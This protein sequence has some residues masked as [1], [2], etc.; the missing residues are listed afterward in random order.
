MS[1]TKLL[2]GFCKKIAFIQ[3]GLT[4]STGYDFSNL[5]LSSFL[6][7]CNFSYYN[8]LIFLF[9]STLSSPKFIN[10]PTFVPDILPIGLHEL[11]PDFLRILVQE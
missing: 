1:M 3:T 4:G 11:W 6:N 9:I 7:K 10:N 5:S 8:T 2:S